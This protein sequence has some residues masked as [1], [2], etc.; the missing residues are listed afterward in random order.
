MHDLSTRK[1]TIYVNNK[2]RFDRS[3][4]ITYTHDSTYYDLNVTRRITELS[5]CKQAKE[6][7][8]VK[9]KEKTDFDSMIEAKLV[10][11]NSSI[12]PK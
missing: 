9:L 5:G 4:K 6:E 1:I 10:V 12:N 2:D 11:Q 3:A 8:L 7:L